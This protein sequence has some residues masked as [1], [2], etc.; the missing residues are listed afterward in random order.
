MPPSHCVLVIEDDPSSRNYLQ[1]LLS[2]WGLQVLLAADGQT[3]LAMAIEHL[4]QAIITDLDMPVMDG[5]NTI[6]QLK[7][8]SQTKAI[9]VV[10]L[11]GKTTTWDRD[12]AYEKGVDYFLAKPAD[13]RLLR[14]LFAGLRLLSMP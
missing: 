6:Q 4:P 14:T 9:P 5:W 11:T 7:S 1:Q 2:S 12:A 3:G 10:A 13:T 8:Q